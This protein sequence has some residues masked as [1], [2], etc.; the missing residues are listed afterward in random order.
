MD[1]VENVRRHEFKKASFTHGHQMSVVNTDYKPLIQPTQKQFI[2]IYLLGLLNQHVIKSRQY[3]GSKLILFNNLI[4]FNN[5]FLAFLN[6]AQHFCLFRSTISP[7]GMNSSLSR[8][9]AQAE[10]VRKQTE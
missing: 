4:R 2:K 5:S 10:P 9:S 8:S 6:R 7:T 3:S 1:K